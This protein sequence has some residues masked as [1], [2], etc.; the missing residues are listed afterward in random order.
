MNTF[1]EDEQQ[2]ILQHLDD[3]DSCRSDHADNENSHVLECLAAANACGLYQNQLEPNMTE[4]PRSQDEQTG[5]YEEEI[6]AS[7]TDL[8]NVWQFIYNDRRNNWKENMT[9][10]TNE[11]QNANDGSILEPNIVSYE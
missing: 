2:D 11:P 1:Y 7:A 6:M 3:I 4:I 5:D 10:S 9:I 8:E